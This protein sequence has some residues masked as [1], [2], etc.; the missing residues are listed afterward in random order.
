MTPMMAVELPTPRLRLR[1][2]SHH[3]YPVELFTIFA[4]LAH[5]L[6][7]VLVEPH[8]VLLFLQAL[9]AEASRQGGRRLA[10]AACR[11]ISP[12]LTPSRGARCT[13]CHLPPLACRPCYS[14]SFSR[15]LRRA[16]REIVRQPRVLAP[17]T[18]LRRLDRVQ[19]GDRRAVQGDAFERLGQSRLLFAGGGTG[20]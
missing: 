9:R 2:L 15:A 18:R 5:D 3:G 7:D 10:R 13:L 12:K 14:A 8:D 17:S 4:V 11:I 20:A 16:T 1:R 19:S 6:G